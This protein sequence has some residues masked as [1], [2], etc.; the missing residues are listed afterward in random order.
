MSPEPALLV[1]GV[2]TP[3]VVSRG[4]EEA[5]GATGALPFCHHQQ[6]VLAVS[7]QHAQFAA[8]MLLKCKG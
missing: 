5:T 6:T 7:L 3:P 1:P 4:P 2:Q 8:V